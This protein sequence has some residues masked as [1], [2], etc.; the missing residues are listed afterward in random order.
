M[1]EDAED[2]EILKEIEG[3]GTEATRS[4]IIETIKRNGYIEVKKNIVSVTEKGIILCKAIEGSLLSSPSM[5]AKWESYLKKI[6]EGQGSMEVFLKNI[7][8]FL[9]KTI[10][11]APKKIESSG[12]S[13]AI[14]KQQ[15]SMTVGTCPVCKKG[16]ML[17][18]KTFFGCTEYSNGC[19]FSI[20]KTIA[21]KKL[22]QKNIK[23]LLE[24][25]VTPKIKGFKSKADKPFDAMLV[26]EK[27][28]VS[29][30]F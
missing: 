24:K 23:D 7:T 18:R 30:K 14:K 21:R 3:I 11:E 10:D 20:S 8:R 6:G 12:V 22:T 19:K 29:F 16:G 13:D 5:T 4:G 26:I 9:N 1:V 15:E 2:S 25:G 27:E 28:K 17:D